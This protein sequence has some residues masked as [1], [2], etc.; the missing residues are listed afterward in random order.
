MAHV[1]HNCRETVKV[2]KR[3]ILQERQNLRN[4]VRVALQ[5]FKFQI[6]DKEAFSKK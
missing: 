2:Q 1:K 5:I 6:R 4:F 3:E